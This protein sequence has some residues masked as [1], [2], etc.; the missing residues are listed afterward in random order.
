MQQQVTNLLYES[1]DTSILCVC[2]S[3]IKKE[4]WKDHQIVCPKRRLSCPAFIAFISAHVKFEKPYW[5]IFGDR[6]AEFSSSLVDSNCAPSLKE[7]AKL[8]V[9]KNESNLTKL[10]SNKLPSAI[11]HTLRWECPTFATKN[12]LNKHMAGSCPYYKVHCLLIP[13]FRPMYHGVVPSNCHNNHT[14]PNHELSRQ[15]FYEHSLKGALDPVS[16]SLPP[17]PIFFPYHCSACGQHLP[18]S[19]AHICIESLPDLP[20]PPLPASE[21][22][23]HGC[24]SILIEPMKSFN[25]IENVCKSCGQDKNPI[26]INTLPRT[27]LEHQNM[28]EFWDGTEKLSVRWQ[29]VKQDLLKSRDHDSQES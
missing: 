14:C 21:V 5:K 19:D 2:T 16:Q 27:P 7:I 6:Y 28:I 11:I 18:D 20:S 9:L 8:Q 23:C 22:I 29:D 1:S 25:E 17:K 26:L 4:D 12:E 13:V 10:K 15:E 24:K 3:K